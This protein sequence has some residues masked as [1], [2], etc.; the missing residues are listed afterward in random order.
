MESVQKID[1]QDWMKAVETCKV[2]AALS[3]GRA[4]FVGGCVRNAL[5]GRDVEDIDIATKWNPQEVTERLEAAGIKVVPTGID[6]GTVTAVVEGKPF[7]I[8]SLRKDIETD[9][10]RAVVSFTQDWLEDARRRDFTINTLLADMEGNIF[11][12][13][14]QGLDDLHKRRVVFV[15]DPAQR[16]AEDYLRILRLFRF[17]ASYGD[18]EIDVEALAACRAAAGKI[19]DLS[20]E[21]ITQEFFKI[22]AVD[23]PEDILG[24]MFDNK[25]L[26][27]LSYPEYD[28]EL[29]G[30]F[31]DFQKRYGLISVSPR[32]FML[33]EMRLENVDAMEKFLLF[34][35]VFRKDIEALSKVLKLDDLGSEQAVRAAVYRQGRVA[36]AQAL[37][38]ELVT[39][40]VVNGFAPKA[41]EI[42]QSWDIPDFPL[43]GEDL[44]KAGIPEGPEL[45]QKL[46]EVEDQWIAEDFK[47][48]R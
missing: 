41:L 33:A 3:E 42:I 39:D 44:M 20:K 7:E 5:I 19:A 12:P 11:D 21:R 36:G 43:S 48:G 24:I 34:P 29:M 45:G 38:V 8:T 30:Y 22:V 23:K 14:G 13:I 31:C 37:I 40:R 2:M 15:G 25:V 46:R 17:H 18:G 1:P 47:P 6:H 27:E 26:T 28:A 35:K 9:G 16:I 10:R 32:L 4:L